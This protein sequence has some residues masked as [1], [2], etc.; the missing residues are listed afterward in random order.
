M[1]CKF[2]TRAKWADDKKCANYDYA[3]QANGLSLSDCITKKELYEYNQKRGLTN[4]IDPF[5]QLFCVRFNYS[6]KMDYYWSDKLEIE[7]SEIAEMRLDEEKAGFYSTLIG[8][9]DS[10]LTAPPKKYYKQGEKM[11]TE[12]CETTD[13]TE[14]KPQ[15]LG[16]FPLPF[17]N[18]YGMCNRYS[19]ANFM[20]SETNECTQIVDLVTDCES[21][22]N[23]EFYT[24]RVKF[25]AG[26]AQSSANPPLTIDAVYKLQE[27]A[28][29][30][31]EYVDTGSITISPS[32]F[33]S[34]STTCTGVLK[35]ISYTVI[36][37]EVDPDANDPISTKPYLKVD[38]ISALVVLQDEPIQ[39]VE[40]LD[41]K[42]MV[43]VQQR[44][45]I[46]F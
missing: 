3:S 40:D 8:V 17:A 32:V 4:Y 15:F 25:F 24:T 44:F 9:A 7:A 10:G 19:S 20:E 35:E 41:G 26:Q 37:S 45:S 13:Q 34:G 16:S 29:N 14:C 36:V 6:P 11:Y 42:A 30:L 39:G 22:L 33:D 31:L 12:I 23:P 1:D 21:T 5:A 18:V 27:N 28:S 43:S 2:D 38:S 46:K